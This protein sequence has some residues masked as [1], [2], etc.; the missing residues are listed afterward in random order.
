MEIVADVLEEG[1]DVLLDYLELSA[2]DVA[3][4]DRH[5]VEGDV[6]T[7]QLAQPACPRNAVQHFPR[8]LV[9][10][11]EQ[12]PHLVQGVHFLGLDVLQRLALPGHLLVQPL[13]FRHQSF[14][15]VAVGLG[16]G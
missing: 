1:I 5:V 2:Q 8:L 15:F 14:H 11:S 4:L 13:H 12:I 16:F 6:Q 3:P 7:V 9:Q 10:L